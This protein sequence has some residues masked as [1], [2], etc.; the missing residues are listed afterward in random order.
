[1]SSIRDC[2]VVVNLMMEVEKQDFAIS[3]FP[4]EFVFLT[5][6]N[7]NFSG[8]Q[9]LTILQL[10]YLKQ[11]MIMRKMKTTHSGKSFLFMNRERESEREIER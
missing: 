9:N 11:T 5:Q 4:S 1:M 2:L 8:K 10:A 7:M 6:G 3:S